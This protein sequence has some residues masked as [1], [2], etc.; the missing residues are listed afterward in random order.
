MLIRRHF[1]REASFG[2]VM[3][4]GLTIRKSPGMS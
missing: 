4:K 3:S 1:A 2:G